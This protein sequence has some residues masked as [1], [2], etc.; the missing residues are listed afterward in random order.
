M[1]IEKVISADSH[2]LEP[3]EIYVER[4]LKKFRDVA[5]KVV[6]NPGNREG[7]FWIFQDQPLVTAVEGFFAGPSRDSYD[8]IAEH[9]KTASYQNRFP[10]SYD[11]SARLKDMEKDGTIAEVMYPT[12]PLGL[13]TVKDAELQRDLF[14]VYNDWLAEFCSYAP[15]SLIG[16]GLISIWDIDKAVLEIRRCAKIG[17]RGIVV[18]SYPPEN[19]GY[20][21]RI[22]DPLWAEA[23]SNGT[24][25]SLHAF[26]GY[27]IEDSSLHPRFRHACLHHAAQRS[28]TQMIYYGVFD[29]FPDLKVVLAEFDIGWVPH[30]LWLADDKYRMRHE[31]PDITPQKKPS[32]Y[33]RANVFADFIDDPIGLK[34][35]D[36]IGEDNYMWSND[37]PHWESSWPRSQ[38]Y[39]ERNFDGVSED[40]KRK[41]TRDNAAKLYGIKM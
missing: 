40:I 31:N 38:E 18:I 25:I 30:F 8:E 1:T 16:L 35:T 33:F 14:R 4:M 21:Q 32:D 24:P 23:E 17:L 29:R 27:G 11:P 37:Y 6:R 39:I 22:Y 13:F 2:V 7:E 12:Y 26:T 34:N 15:N 5:P 3:S 19:L 10:G 41:I 28:L 9:L 20:N 36:I